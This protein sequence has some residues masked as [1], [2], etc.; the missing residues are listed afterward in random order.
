MAEVL[1]YDQDVQFDYGN[2][3]IS[4]KCVRVTTQ[5]YGFAS[6]YLES[7][8]SLYHSTMP[9]IP[10][11]DIRTS[12][13]Q[14]GVTHIVLL[15]LEADVRQEYFEKPVRLLRRYTQSQKQFEDFSDDSDPDED[16]GTD[17]L[18][19]CEDF[20]KN[21]KKTQYEKLIK[22]RF[23]GLIER[24]SNERPDLDLID[25]ARIQLRTR[26]LIIGSLSFATKTLDDFPPTKV[27]H[28][29]HFGV[30]TRFQL[31]K[32]GRRLLQTAVSESKNDVFFVFSPSQ[33]VRF[34]RN[35]GFT[36]DPLICGRFQLLSDSVDCVPMA[37]ILNR[38]DSQPVQNNWEVYRNEAY[39]RYSQEAFFV[40]K[41]IEENNELKMKNGKY[42]KIQNTFEQ[43][44]AL[45]RSRCV[46]YE[47]LVQSLE[48]QLLAN[49]IKPKVNQDEIIQKVVKSI[50]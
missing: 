1:Q 4:C 37:K 19:K 7:M 18:L 34:F 6:E 39:K 36:D 11:E 31:M 20:I 32:A 40:K 15:R 17:L 25:A 21:R 43:Q 45:E 48:N 13:Q 28:L 41:L 23:P 24:C 38:I 46:M 3:K 49:G 9:H 44:L 33:T 5:T 35:S 22:Q 27:T 26:D 12:L 14:D 16:I 2:K 29:L 42:E 10:T 8:V 47:Q 30:R 50:K